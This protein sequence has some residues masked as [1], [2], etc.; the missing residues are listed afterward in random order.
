[1]RNQKTLPV[2]ATL[3]VFAVAIWYCDQGEEPAGT[4]ETRQR[5][6]KT[7]NQPNEEHAPSPVSAV[8]ETKLNL[9]R[10]VSADWKTLIDSP[11]DPKF[12]LS[13]ELLSVLERSTQTGQ[14]VVLERAAADRDAV[15]AR[16]IMASSLAGG[17]W[18]RAVE[19]AG[20]DHAVLSVAL[21]TDGL[22]HARVFS[23]SRDIAW[24]GTAEQGSALTLEAV[25]RQVLAPVCAA[26]PTGGG[27]LEVGGATGTVPLRES[28]P[29]A[30][31]VLYLDFDGEQV[32]NT[33]WNAQYREGEQIAALGS[34]MGSNEIERV[35]MEV[36]E[37]FRPFEVNVTTDRRIY[38]EASPQNRM[39]A[40]FTLSDEW[41]NENFPAHA[42]TGGIAGPGTFGMESHL[43]CWVFTSRVVGTSN[44]AVAC[45]HELGHTLGLHHDGQRTREY[46][47]GHGEGPTSWAPIM[48]AG[49]DRRVTQW[50]AGGYENYQNL[51]GGDEDDI[52]LIKEH[53]GER[54]DEDRDRP[55]TAR[56]IQVTAAGNGT[57]EALSGDGVITSQFDADYLYYQA[58][59]PGV[60]LLEV[61]PFGSTTD[62]HGANIDV[63]L[64]L[65]D[66]SGSV[67][68]TENPAGEL[69]ASARY[70]I[71]L[72]GRY[73]LRIDGTGKDER[74]GYS[75]YGS[76]GCYLIEGSYTFS[77][78]LAIVSQPGSKRIIEGQD[79]RL[80]VTATGNN[81]L[82]QW[83]K[84]MAA[85][86]LWE[87]IGAST[88]Q[89]ELV[90][91]GASLGDSGLYRVIVTED[92]ESLTSAPA[93]LTVDPNRTAE[94]DTNGRILQER[95]AEPEPTTAPMDISTLTKMSR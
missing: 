16:V 64:Q 24:R 87:N 19:L 95:R 70:E 37:D 49:Y 80:S 27:G 68:A 83:Q 17:G 63:E 52:L 69:S 6:T 42:K 25:P 35:W 60:L 18:L 7:L 54:E 61:K 84:L 73:F 8:H 57:G 2:W 31:R 65:L 20:M 91:A 47:G 77:T 33:L 28:L 9:K 40:V 79:A 34:G 59:T 43:L 74:E 3:T 46:Y 55:D 82:F 48:G 71:D 13:P 29:G 22:I 30:S 81:L 36:S 39:M 51:E 21:E 23:K 45:S 12:N 32:S 5:Q 66:E 85:P 15:T 26:P 56:A 58:Q 14:R 53:L 62:G 94:R 93:R 1:M 44:R 4:T 90:I 72:P 88:S 41:Y 50:S 11:G 38:E 76:V 92:G 89:P 10:I 78:A 67:L 86:S 75:H